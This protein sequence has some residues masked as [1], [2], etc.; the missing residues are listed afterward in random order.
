MTSPA[1][2]LQSGRQF[3]SLVGN[4]DF[5]TTAGDYAKYRAGFPAKLF[6]RL[7]SSFQVGLP[8][9]RILDLGTGTGTLARGFALRGANATGLDPSRPMLDA[10]RGLDAEVAASVT[11]VV[12]TAEDTGLP[13]SSFDVVTAG[14]CWHWF[15]PD[16]AAAEVRRVLVP[17]GTVALCSFDWVLMPGNVI[18]LSE[19]LIKRHNPAWNLGNYHGVHGEYIKPIALAG[20]THVETFSF[21]LDQPYTHE[22]WRGRIRASAGIGATLSAE[23]V[24]AFDLEHAEALAREFPDPLTALHRCFALVARSPR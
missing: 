18:D 17:G 1:P 24:A 6:D 21:D 9:Q 11:Y 10:A 8:G 4:L 14:Q 3:A 13:A 15:D 23:A 12:G 16:R 5:G 19:R 20:F 7:A 22:A 2:T